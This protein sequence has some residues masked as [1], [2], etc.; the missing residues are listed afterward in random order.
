MPRRFVTA[1]RLRRRWLRFANFG[2]T[3]T[4]PLSHRAQVLFDEH[5]DRVYRD[6]D[7]LF[8]ALMVGQWIFAIVLALVW[9]PY[10]W[11]GK[12]SSL[13]V[14]LYAAIFLGGLLSSFPIALTRLAPGSAFTRNVIACAQM[15]WSALLIHLSGGRIETHF[16]VF[17]SLAFVAFYRDWKVLIPATLVVVGDHLVRGLLW[18]ESVYGIANPEWWRFLEHAFWVTFTDIVLVLACLRGVEEMRS[19]AVQRAELEKLS[20]SELNKKSQALAKALEELRSSQETLVRQEKLAALGQLAASVAHEVKNPLAT[21]KGAANFVSKR[22]DASGSDAATKDPRVKQFLEIIDR[23]VRACTKI[24]SDLLDFARER[25]MAFA[26][27]AV[28][29]LVKEALGVVVLPAR[30]N[31]TIATEIPETLGDVEVDRDQLRQVVV[32]LVQ[33]AVEA[34]PAERAGKVT[35]GAEENGTSWRLKVQDDGAGISAEVRDKIFQPLFT[36][37]NKGTGLG[38]AIVASVANRHGGKIDV[39][40]EIGRGTTVT[41]ELPRRPSTPAPSDAGAGALGAGSDVVLP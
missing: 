8:A 14:H 28:A 9:S 29:P 16:H 11:E 13:H 20:E 23:E 35:V 34:I 5:R 2:E 33:N 37:K 18:P 36:T 27:C 26:P 32:N 39:A 22:L 3:M 15:L 40:S 24:V 1:R 19:I 10:A 7:R 4:Q 31:V 17:G 21:I 38:L 12:V 6:A 30:A 25:P 41:L